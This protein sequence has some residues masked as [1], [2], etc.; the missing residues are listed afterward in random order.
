MPGRTE[1]RPEKVKAVESVKEIV[2]NSQSIIITDY[3]GMTVK[4]LTDLRRAVLPS[5]AEYKVIKNKV[6]IRA[7]PAEDKILSQLKGT[8]AVL[9]SKKEV[10]EPAKQLINFVKENEKPQILGGMLDGNFLTKEGIVELSKLPSRQELLTKVVQCCNGPVYG[11]VNVLAGTLRKLIYAL[12]AVK[13]K[14]EP[15]SAKATEGKQG[16]EK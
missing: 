8:I 2:A 9:F 15:S 4:Q 1:V 11:F 12:N 7:L 14:K 5:G 6:S 3:K 13:D 16:G 10:V